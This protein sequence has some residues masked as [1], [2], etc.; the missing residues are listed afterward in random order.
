MELVSVKSPRPQNRRI[1]GQTGQLDRP[2]PPAPR[3]VVVDQ[4]ELGIG[5]LGPNLTS[6]PGLA[7]PAGP[8]RR[9]I[10]ASTL[11]DFGRADATRLFSVMEV[12]GIYMKTCQ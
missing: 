8:C 1:D 12:D 3:P 10:V 7:W 11:T 5:P 6:S 9:G 2:P 4:R